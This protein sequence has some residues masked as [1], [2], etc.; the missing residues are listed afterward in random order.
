MPAGTFL[1]PGL[2]TSNV[3]VSGGGTDNYV[4][5]A[6]DSETIQ[7]ESK[8]TFD[9]TTLT[10]D[11]NLTFTGAQTITTSAGNLTIDT[12]GAILQE[13]GGISKQQISTLTTT[14]GYASSVVTQQGEDATAIRNMSARYVIDLGD[15][16]TSAVTVATF[17]V[18][19]TSSKYFRAYVH[20]I[21][22]GGNTGG[23]G[24]GA[25]L[26]RIFYIDVSNT[27]PDTGT[28]VAGTDDGNGPQVTMTDPGSSNVALLQVASGDA[29]GALKG[30]LMIFELYH[31]PGD[32]DTTIAV[33]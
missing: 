6:V 23:H 26:D 18:S 30:G 7:G 11:G 28:S 14:V 2:T 16:I 24:D 19:A 17:T 25:I 4:M 1:P 27:Y 21:M 32:G 12:A 5:T 15:L 3:K 20:V 22:C 31:P 10:V 13:V 9:G 8:L 33:T 29:S